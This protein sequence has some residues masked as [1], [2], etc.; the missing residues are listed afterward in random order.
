MQGAFRT[1]LAGFFLAAL[2]A[3]SALAGPEV[4]IADRVYLVPDT[5]AKVLTFWMIVNAGCRDE[6][7]GDCRGIAHYL[8]H[9]VFLGRGRRHD[10]EGNLAF[11]AGQTNAFTNMTTTAYYQTTPAREGKI[12]ED[13]DRLFSLFEIGRAHV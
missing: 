1:A 12:E 11:A 8:E 10:E 7:G 9:L 3:V 6:E 2:S 5:K 13:L 4:K